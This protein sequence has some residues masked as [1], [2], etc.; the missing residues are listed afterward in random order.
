MWAHTEAQALASACMY[1][2]GRDMTMCSV[3]L[4]ACGVGLMGLMGWWLGADGLVVGGCAMCQ[5]T[6]ASLFLRAV[7]GL[8]P[9]RRPARAQ[10]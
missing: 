4:F 5:T 6:I 3:C 10:V 8:G 2:R 1:K 9:R 7:W